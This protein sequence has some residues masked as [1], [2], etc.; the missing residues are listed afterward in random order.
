MT[1]RRAAV[2]ALAL[3]LAG[4]LLSG[5]SGAAPEFAPTPVGEPPSEP[6]AA[7]ATLGLGETAWILDDA[8]GASGE[9]VG[10]TVREI[11]ELDP[12]AIDGFEDEPDFAGYTPYAVVVQYNWPIAGEKDLQNLDVPV[13]PIDET[14]EITRWLANDIGNVAMGDADACGIALPEPVAGSGENL[15]CFVALSN[16]GPVAGAVYNGTDRG[17]V[18]LDED[19]P[20]AATPITWRG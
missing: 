2:P 19:H 9:L 20:F 7:G 18:F 3:A 6:T 11:R 10:T 4:L 17:D 5:C 13:L 8:E 16:T 14:G 12:A 15:E 1:R